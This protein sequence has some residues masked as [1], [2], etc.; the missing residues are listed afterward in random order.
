MD[1]EVQTELVDMLYHLGESFDA[2]VHELL[3]GE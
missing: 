1:E 3:H 2:Q